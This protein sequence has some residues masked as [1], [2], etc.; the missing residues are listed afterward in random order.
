[1]E[2]IAVL[3][4]ALIT[5]FLLF[6]ALASIVTEHSVPGLYT[7]EYLSRLAFET[8]IET[9]LPGRC[10]TVTSVSN[11][12]KIFVD[13]VE[14]TRPDLVDDGRVMVHRIQGFLSHLSP[15]S[16]SIDKMTS[17]SVPRPSSSIVAMR[18]MLTDAMA[19][20]RTRGYIILALALRVKYPKL[21]VME[22]ITKF[23]LDDA[24][25]FLA[26]HPYVR[27]VRFHIVPNRR[28]MMADLEKLPASKVIS[29]LQSGESLVVTTASGEGILAPMRLNYVRIKI[30]DLI[31]NLKIVVHGL[32][33]SFSHLRQTDPTDAM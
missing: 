5:A 29:T 33:V 7:A 2:S 13:G 19:R 14:I 28:L 3:I 6:A 30:P 1:M 22:N 25:I 4:S 12:S 11:G 16:C 23:A 10:L 32:A 9:I 26:E 31:Q 8:N 27:D 24:A 18:L 20:L 17:L 21:V 15:Y